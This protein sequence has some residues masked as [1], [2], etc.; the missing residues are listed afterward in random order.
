MNVPDPF[1]TVDVIVEFPPTHK[2]GLSAAMDTVGC[3]AT[4]T[5]KTFDIGSV[6]P[7]A[8]SVKIDNK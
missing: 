4:T 3:P 8:A 5:L 7:L 1:N 6:Q 2:F